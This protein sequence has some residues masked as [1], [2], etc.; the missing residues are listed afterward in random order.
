MTIPMLPFRILVFLLSCV[1]FALLVFNIVTGSLGPDPGQTVTETLGLSALQLLIVTLLMT[2][3]ARWTQWTGWI[4]VRRMVGLFAFFYATLHLMAFLQ[5]ILG[6]TDLW[7]TF[8]KRPYIIF[9]SIAFLLLIPL[10]VTSTKSMMR[11]VGRRWKPLH[12]LIYPAVA[13][14]WLHFMF[15]ARSDIAEMVIYGLVVVFLLGIRGYWFGWYSLIPLRAPR[16]S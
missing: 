11:R 7:A 14:A 5:F 15:Q 13:L 12:R 6:W 2:P 16:R 4:K 10:A 1:P 9:G 8:T 3:L